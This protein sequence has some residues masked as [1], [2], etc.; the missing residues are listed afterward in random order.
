MT[1][2]LKTAADHTALA[3]FRADRVEWL[4]FPSESS[5]LTAAAAQKTAG[6]GTLKAY[7]KLGCPECSRSYLRAYGVR[8][9]KREYCSADCRT[10]KPSKAHLAAI[11]GRKLD[12]AIADGDT[13]TI[14]EMYAEIQ[15]ILNDSRFRSAI[16]KRAA[17][18][19]R[20][21]NAAK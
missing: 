19:K 3:G 15:D 14:F 18:R 21:R 6:N 5:Y 4:V 11:V 16:M 12:A 17:A 20:A 9:R 1:T 10:F 7:V 8:G 2:S 13:A